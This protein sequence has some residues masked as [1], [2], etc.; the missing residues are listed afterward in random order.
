MTEYARVYLDGEYLGEHYGGFTAFEFDKVVEAGRHTLI[1][2]VDA[3]STEDTIPLWAVDWHHY[4][5]IIRSVEVSEYKSVAIKSMRAEY[6]L[7][8]QC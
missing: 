3:R 2:M 8:D 6:E 5:G 1:V 7:S 4:C